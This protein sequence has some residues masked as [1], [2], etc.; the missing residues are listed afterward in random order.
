MGMGAAAAVR[1]ARIA[2]RLRPDA[3]D[4]ELLGRYAAGDEAA[5]RALV[6]RH[7]ALVLGV[8][9]RALRSA[10]DA[11]DAA[12]ATF[13]V[14]ARKAAGRWHPSVAHW[15]HATARR[16]ARNA[17]VAAARRRA[18]ERTAAAPEAVHPP[19]HVSA[20]ELLRAL[21]DELGR[22]P[23]RYRGPL[24][25]CYLEGLTRDE[26]A[27]RLGLPPGA[28]KINLERG[29]QRLAAALARRGFAP[30]GV[31]L[32]VA[33]ASPAGAAP[34]RL[35]DSV[36]AA[37]AGQPTAAVAAL[38]QGFAMT[39]PKLAAVALVLAAGVAAGA[40]L[41]AGSAAPPEL[42]PPPRAVE[43]PAPLVDAL[44]D[45]L[46][47]GAVARLG[48]NRLHHGENLQRVLVS[49]DGRH[50]LSQGNR[51][52]KLW[53]A[54]TGK[55][56]PVAGGKYP[57]AAVL[58][59]GPAG[60]GLAVV[61]QTDDGWVL[62]D[63]ATGEARLTMPGL[64]YNPGQLRGPGEYPSAPAVRPD[65]RGVAFTRLTFGSDGIKSAVLV[66]EA[67]AAEPA[68]LTTGQATRLL[69]SPDGGRLAV[70]YD[71]D[72]G[73]EVWDPAA[74]KLLLHAPDANRSLSQSFAFSHDGRQFAKEQAG[75]NRVQFWDL[76]TGKEL[77]P[78]AWDRKREWGWAL[79][80]APD[81]KTAVT[82]ADHHV[83]RVWDLPARK[84]IREMPC[85]AWNGVDAGWTPDGKRMVTA[86][87][88]DVYVRDAATGKLVVSYGHTSTIFGVSWSA[89]GSRVTT[90]AGYTDVRPRVWDAATGRP[91]PDEPRAEGIPPGATTVP[92]TGRA[93]VV[94]NGKR[95]RVW[96]SAGG[97]EVARF[98]PGD[99]PI[100][101]ARLSRD[102]RRLAALGR[103]DVHVWDLTENR[104]VVRVPH[105]FA[106]PDEVWLT[107]DG[108]RVVA[109]GA[110]DPPAGQPR[111]PS[112]A[113]AAWE[114]PS[115][116]PVRRLVSGPGRPQHVSADGRFLLTGT[117]QAGS[118]DGRVELWD[119][120]AGG[121][122]RPLVTRGGDD[123]DAKD[124][125]FARFAPDG[126]TAAVGFRG[127]D[128]LVV[129]TATG[130]RRLTFDSR[131]REVGFGVAFSPAGDRLA[132]AAGRSVLVWDVTGAGRD[133]LPTSA[134]AAWVD[135][136]ADDAA[137]GFAA[138]RY[139]AARPGE[140]VAHLR[141]RLKPVPAADPK[142]VATL[143]DR[144]GAPA[145]ADREA[146]EK[147]LAALG[148][149]AGPALAGAARGPSAEVR[150]RAGRLLARLDAKP[151]G[152]RLRAVRAVEALE[153]VGTVEAREV[154]KGLAGGAAGA[155]L[156]TE[157]AAA[158]SRLTAR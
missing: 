104:R 87:G 118:E 5:F 39:T 52:W 140:A 80:L 142:A 151:A 144:L 32:A 93:V 37:L 28:V 83:Y 145:F 135:L 84:V 16:V 71:P 19:D 146:A 23:D 67:G 55:E 99:E 24:V 15:L 137:R 79:A 49:P 2:E 136:A 130:G 125:M 3:T 89:D 103:A 60:R 11:E 21:D 66:W 41:L 114:V 51:T 107:P 8:C 81:G 100:T 65:G 34:P 131:G 82:L 36:A 54:D 1:A 155:T 56:L 44:G 22:L 98:E 10:A 31:L 157:A 96:E 115:G 112:Y 154:L 113:A 94:E 26:A 119:L 147:E 48:T 43:A 95:V 40:G 63:A 46:P 33:V 7:A 45:P 85:F 97:R 134:D 4:R 35:A 102:G 74:R 78:L 126:R 53:E 138:V 156:T 123:P 75:A 73:T 124:V 6:D 17:R 106:A 88:D 92:G 20:A 141:D 110:A 59:G 101:G 143:V 122:P 18:R 50:I 38:A 29:R 69:Y 58:A 68:V 117:D 121:G 128:V 9:R 150:N 90:R 132:T 152:D 27:R 14:L 30:G 57:P 149:A 116:S 86:E 133:D 47:P 120:H 139:L 108:G 25:L 62:A 12:Q 76:D 127:P 129:E 91:L 77:P 158:V 148:E 13:L 70:H 42:A 72:R 105:G 64:R 111:R 109:S 153:R 61:V